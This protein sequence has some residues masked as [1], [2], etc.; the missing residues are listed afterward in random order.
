MQRYRDLIVWQRAVE[1]VE[2]TYRLTE[3]LPRSEIFGLTSQMR[4]AAVSIP[5]N[6]AEGFTRK[7]KTEHAQ[8]LRIAFGSGAELET[9]ILLCEK[10][11][12]TKTDATMTVRAKLE[13]TMKMLNKLLSSLETK[14]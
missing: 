10:L 4:R 8:F 1:V 6:I 3:K 13:E 5:S 12:F 14:N 9:Q 7:H 2:A 11:G